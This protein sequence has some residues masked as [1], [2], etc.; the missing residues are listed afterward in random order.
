MPRV[1]YLFCVSL[2]RTT[3]SLP[4]RTF[5]TT[6]RYYF[7]YI[8]VVDLRHSLAQSVRTMA[9]RVLRVSKKQKSRSRIVTTIIIQRAW[10]VWVNVRCR[11][12]ATNGGGGE[13]AFSGETRL[14]VERVVKS[15]AVV[16]YFE[17]NE[18]A[19]A[20]R[21][22]KCVRP[23]GEGREVD[24]DESERDGKSF[25]EPRIRWLRGWGGG[26]QQHCVIVVL[27]LRIGEMCRL[28]TAFTRTAARWWDTCDG[29][30]GHQTLVHTIYP[31]GLVRTS[32]TFVYIY[33]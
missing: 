13:N 3:I 14:A 33:L 17:R 10:A 8:Y 18:I 5:T 30:S 24:R 11:R 16:V 21:N 9:E 7:V 31:V 2:S 28:T 32:S 19:T 4:T 23:S 15:R 20:R 27:A 25:E 29:T 12:R 22:G 1:R 26:K 6:T